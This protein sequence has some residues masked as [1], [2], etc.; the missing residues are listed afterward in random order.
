MDNQENKQKLPLW[1]IL[2][3]AVL[4]AALAVAIVLLIVNGSKDS[5]PTEP[6]TLSTEAPE[7]TT[8]DVEEPTKAPAVSGYGNND[9]TALTSYTVAD[10]MPNDENMAVVIAINE[11]GE[12]CLTNGELQIYYWIEFYSFMNTYG[13]YASLFGLDDSIPLDQQASMM[14]GYTWEQYF[15]ESAVMRYAENYALAQAALES[16]ISLTEA[17]EEALADLEDPNGTFAAEATAHGHD[18]PEA[19]IQATFGAGVGIA[20]Y[21]NYLRNY[22]LAYDYYL[23]QYTEQESLL[24]ETEI[25]A[26]FD[27]NAE[28][29]AQ[30]GI[31]KVDTIDVRHILIQPT[32][33]ANGEYSDEAW[34][35]AE[36]E[37]NSIYADW[38]TNPT[39]DYFAQL[40]TTHST[41]GGSSSAGGLYEG[42]YPGQ[43]VEAFND[44]CFDESRVAG[45]HG[46]VQTPYGYHIMFFVNNSRAWYTAAAQDLAAQKVSPIVEEKIAQY[47]L[48]FD[49]T[50]ARI[51]DL[52]T[53]SVA[54]E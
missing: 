10:A 35:T 39:E 7:P 49:Y 25:E 46:I 13:S 31:T 34:A 27:E 47:P 53:A 40:A 51:Y 43:M 3:V 15:L 12:D 5:D 11:A 17:D 44:W 23:A 30:N 2:L 9:A 37:A 36:A 52:L 22:Y 19:Y 8:E 29:Y 14:E 6:T 21:Q 20:D 1:G 45:D 26:F 33:D 41:D 28:T 38:Q 54:S 18:S 42:V 50:K 32:E 48:Q 4:F 16:G 24:T